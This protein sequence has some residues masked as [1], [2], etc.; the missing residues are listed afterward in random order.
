MI[1]R[2]VLSRLKPGSIVINVARGPIVNETALIEA[3]NS[4]HVAGAGLDVVEV[5]P[6]HPASPL[7]TMDNVV[8]TP[9]VGAQSK[10]RVPDTI[11]FVSQNIQRY[12]RGE[13]PLNV[14][15]KHLGYPERKKPC[16]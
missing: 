6:L 7:W 10:Y 15:D 9:H 1:N 5:E 8:I 13:L 12:L 4:G 11:R 14:V 2:E 16:V 3:L